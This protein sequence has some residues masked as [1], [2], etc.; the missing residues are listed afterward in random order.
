MTAITRTLTAAFSA[1]SGHNCLVLTAQE[2][3]VI[4]KVFY[5]SLSCTCTFIF[6]SSRLPYLFVWLFLLSLTPFHLLPLKLALYSA[7]V[8][9]PNVREVLQLA[10]KRSLP[11]MIL[12]FVCYFV[13][14][15]NRSKPPDEPATSPNRHPKKPCVQTVGGGCSYE[16]FG[17]PRMRG[18]PPETDNTRPVSTPIKCTTLK[19]SHNDAICS[20]HDVTE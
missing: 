12:C 16:V 10:G 20:F 15:L 11:E 14:S 7:K 19:F 4:Y 8:E 17:S 3:V 2:R 6:S 5:F 1:F 18:F 9:D 13:S